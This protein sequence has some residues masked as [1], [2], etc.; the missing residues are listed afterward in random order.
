VIG[1]ESLV[2]GGWADREPFRVEP[3]FSW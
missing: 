3:P 1:F 2:G